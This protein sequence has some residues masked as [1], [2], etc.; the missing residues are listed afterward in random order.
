MENKIYKVSDECIGCEACIDVAA[1]N[2]EMG[3]NNKAFLKKQPNTDSEI[4]ASNTAIDI[5]PVEAIYIDAKENT[6]KITPIF[7][8]ANIKETLDKHPGLKNVLAKLSPKFEKLQKPA[9]Y[10]TL[11]RFANFKDAAK[12]TG[13]SVCEIL[14][15][16]N[17]YLGVAKE[18]IDNAPEC[19]S[20]NS[21]EE[22]IIG[23]EITWEEVNE[24][25]ILNDDTISEIMKK[26]SSLKAQENLVIISVE[27]P[28][29]LLKAAIGLELKLNIEEGREYRISLF[30]PKEEQKT[31]WYDRKDDFDILDV[32]TMISDPFDIII[33]KAYDTEE[34][35]GF[36]LIQRF[37]PIPIINML[38][39]MGFE[40]QTKIVNEQEIWVYFHKLITEKDDDE[41]DASDKP[42]VVIQSATPVAY[43][44]IMRLLQSN[45]IRKVVNIK[46]LKVWEETEKHLGWI[47]NG[48]AD[49]SFSALITSAK[50]KDNDIKVPAMFVWDNFSILTRGYTASKLEDLIG[51][52]IDTPLF[53]EAPPAKIT[54]Y[55]IEA[56][57]LNYDDFSFSY[58]EPFGRPEEILMNFVRGVSDTVILREPEASYAQK[59]ME[60]MGEKVSVISYNKIWNEIN[61]G[62]GSFPNAGIVFKGE[63]VRKHP[64]E[65]KLFLEE[66]KSAINW[67]NENKKA[68]ANLSFDMM[69][70]PP[71]NVELFL[72]NVKFDY[73][74]G[75]EL[76]EKVKN[77]FQ[78]LVDQGIIDTKVDNK[79]LNMFKLD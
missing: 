23:E 79:L 44:V 75:D 71:E 35:N 16:I 55:V 9:L 70:Q 42:N 61:K 47:V 76:V 63:F 67:V 69:R 73:V 43:P 12:L 57:G 5:C 8:K 25:Y 1:D 60:K 18:L 21:A 30:N 14:H 36:R 19:I 46:E 53:A 15:T 6:E 27:K 72:K 58:G 77:Y 64:E 66:L 49:I 68:A 20:I 31:N 38:K 11:A 29:S 24:R 37:E 3:N 51:H 4:E 45:K 74:S 62:F 28:I 40:H 48:K 32:R 33:K 22:M 26:V 78:I 34:D 59:I 56:K 13:V 39:E 52:V 7:A 2:F 65:A 41:K 50:L 10:N 17:E 54:K